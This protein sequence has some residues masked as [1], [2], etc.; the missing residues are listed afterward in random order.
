MNDGPSVFHVTY[1]RVTLDVSR[2]A[3]SKSTERKSTVSN[4]FTYCSS[5]SLSYNL[6]WV[7]PVIQRNR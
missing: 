2:P 1:I 6:G 5:P 3:V 7:E 4:A